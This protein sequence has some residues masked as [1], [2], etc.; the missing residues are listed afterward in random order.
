MT[1]RPPVLAYCLRSTHDSMISFQ[2][3]KQQ[4][5][6]FTFLANILQAK[7]RLDV[8]LLLFDTVLHARGQMPD[9]DAIGPRPSHERIL[10]PSP[11]LG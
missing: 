3:F 6:S 9:T 11:Q 10:T 5:P 1:F 8:R 4:L 7:E 2:E